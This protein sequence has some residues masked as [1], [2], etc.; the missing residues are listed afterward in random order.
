MALLATSGSGKRRR[1]T[2]SVFKVAMK[3]SAMA[4]SRAV[5]VLPIEGTM[6]TSSR[7]LPN[8]IAVYCLDSTGRCNTNRERC[9]H[10]TTTGLVHTVHRTE[11]LAFSGDSG[12]QQ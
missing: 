10:G 3:L 9:C 6:P 2:S 12:D 5:P 7:R 4:L 1:C 11:G 8:E